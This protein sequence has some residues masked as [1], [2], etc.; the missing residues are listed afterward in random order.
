[1]LCISDK[2]I[3]QVE[4]RK[5][6]RNHAAM[7]VHF[8]FVSQWNIGKFTNHSMTSYCL[9]R[10][11]SIPLESKGR[12]EGTSFHCRTMSLCGTIVK[13]NE[14]HIY[15]SIDSVWHYFKWSVIFLWK[16]NFLKLTRISEFTSKHFFQFHPRVFTCVTKNYQNTCWCLHSASAW[17]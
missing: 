11:S 3:N 5:K 13:K 9:T 2:Q 17:W 12:E 16:N 10:P 6:N 14:I 4:R 7:N 8:F 1:M 15:G